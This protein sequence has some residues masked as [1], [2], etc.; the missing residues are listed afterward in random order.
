MQF[1]VLQRGA[2]FFAVEN[3]AKVGYT[4]ESA[5]LADAHNGFV[6]FG[7]LV[8]SQDDPGA[9]N[10]IHNRHA[11][12]LPETASKMELADIHIPADIVQRHIPGNIITN[13]GN[14]SADKTGGGIG[15]FGGMML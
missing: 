8:F 13:V 5:F 9:E 1:A 15:A 2:A 12:M 7:Q 14:G 10:I 6:G 3:A 4:A 11:G